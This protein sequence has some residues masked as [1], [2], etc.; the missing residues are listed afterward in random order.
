MKLKFEEITFE[1]D[2]GRRYQGQI[3]QRPDVVEGLNLEDVDLVKI[4]LRCNRKMDVSATRSNLPNN[5]INPIIALCGDVEQGYVKW[6]ETEVDGDT[7]SFVVDV[8]D[9][10]HRREPWLYIVFY[11]QEHYYY[12]L[13]DR[14]ET[15]NS[16][17]LVAKKW[18]R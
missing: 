8:I 10:P 11:E 6:G 12:A 15:E 9:N 5:V 13:V 17:T 3:C 18:T 14:I 4:T 7:I 1:R 16:V 2:D